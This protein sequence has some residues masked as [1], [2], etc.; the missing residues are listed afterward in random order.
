MQCHT[1][2]IYFDTTPTGTDK[3]TTMT[4]ELTFQP[5]QANFTYFDKHTPPDFYQVDDICAWPLT[6][7]G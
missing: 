6:K 2:S 3:M 5:C 4:G 1:D 7:I